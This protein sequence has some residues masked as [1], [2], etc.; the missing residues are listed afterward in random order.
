MRYPLLLDSQQCLEPSLPCALR[1]AG[2]MKRCLPVSTAPAFRPIPRGGKDMLHRLVA[3]P[4]AALLFAFVVGSLSFAQEPAVGGTLTFGLSTDPPNLD[5]HVDSGAAAAA[6]KMVVYDSLMTY[7]SDGSIAADLAE[8]WTMSDDGLTYTFELKNNVTF[9]DGTPLTAD[10]VVFSIERILDDSLGGYLA[11]PVG[12]VERVEAV[13]D[14]VVELHL[15]SPNVALIAYLARLESAIVSKEFVESGNDLNTTMMGTGPFMFVSR[16]PGVELKFEKNPA[17]HVDGLPYL[18]ELVFVPY[19]DEQTRVVA[20]ESG[21]VDLIDYVPWK[22][23]AAI[24]DN[25]NLELYEGDASS[26]MTVIFNQGREP[27]DDPLVRR[28]IGYAIPREAVIRVAFFE[29]GAELTG[30]LIPPNSPYYNESLEGFFRYDRERAIELLAEA[31]WTDSDGD[32]YL[33]KDGQRFQA[34]LMS[35]STYGMH[36]QTGQVVHQALRR[37]GLDVDLSLEEWSVVVSRDSEADYDFRIHGL[38]L[39]V[40]DPEALA[41]MFAPGA[42]RARV[43][44]ITNARYT[45]LLEAGAAE[46]DMDKRKTIYREFEE[47]FLE[48]SPWVHLTWRSQGEAARAYVN[49]FSHFPG[50][51]WTHS[52][53]SLAQTWLDQ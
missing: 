27:F 39:L 7:K 53:L 17:Y 20:L 47:L 34:E 25:P 36:M 40:E 52:P 11:G 22:D 26:F 35:T 5:P 37:I 9:H 44:G 30:G 2:S 4:L 46:T 33:D 43:S 18:D 45:E 24:E 48:E 14:H 51:L 23:M 3:R 32:G 15:S 12:V 8:E 10:D 6:V 13:E 19:A 28:A 1:R 29:R 31:G 38:G 41:A 16:E 42:F 50:P 49:G 21:E